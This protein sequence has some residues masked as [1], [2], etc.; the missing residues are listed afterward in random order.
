MRDDQHLQASAVVVQPSMRGLGHE[1]EEKPS[2]DE[3]I[4][5][6]GASRKEEIP[7]PPQLVNVDRQV[8]IR[9]AV[10]SLVLSP[11]VNFNTKSLMALAMSKG[12]PSPG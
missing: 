7:T 5:G 2:E 1:Y 9:Q 8:T 6:G 11:T 3:C 10:P 4:E 12:W